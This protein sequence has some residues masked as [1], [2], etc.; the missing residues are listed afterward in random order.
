LTCLAACFSLSR[1]EAE[2]QGMAS[3]YTI[4]DMVAEF[5]SACG[6]TTAFGIASVQNIPMLRR[7][8]GGTIAGPGA[9]NELTFNQHSA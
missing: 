9:V 7:A 2:F 5:L 3:D 6:V 4:G 1:N 8:F